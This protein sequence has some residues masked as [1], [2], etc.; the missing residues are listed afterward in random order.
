M[1]NLNE[2]L[3]ILDH[4]VKSYTS[5]SSIYESNTDNGISFESTLKRLKLIEKFILIFAQELEIENVDKLSEKIKKDPEVINK[6]INKIINDKEKKSFDPEEFFLSVSN[7]SSSESSN[8][9]SSESSNEDDNSSVSSMDD[10]NSKDSDSVGSNDVID[11]ED[12]EMNKMIAK[13][14]IELNM[15][16]DLKDFSIE[17][18]EDDENEED[19]EEEDNEDKVLEKDEN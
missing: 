6:V 7:D 14:I 3:P 10:I 5:F 4:F 13:S 2:K 1:D 15:R 16:R 11:E 17:K 12:S 18:I 8:D 19:E 9:S